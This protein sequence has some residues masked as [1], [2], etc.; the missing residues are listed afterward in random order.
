MVKIADKAKR[1]QFRLHTIGDNPREIKKDYSK[2]DCIWDTD[3]GTYMFYLVTPNTIEIHRAYPKNANKL[4]PLMGYLKEEA[5]KLG[6]REIV[7]FTSIDDYRGLRLLSQ[8]GF[9]EPGYYSM[10]CRTKVWMD[11]ELV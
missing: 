1:E 2:Y 9:D 5:V 4:F 11:D 10:I 6:I 3:T 8:L 7:T